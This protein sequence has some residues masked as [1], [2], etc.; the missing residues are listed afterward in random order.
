M[1]RLDHTIKYIINR[2]NKINNI[3]THVMKIAAKS[4]ILSRFSSRLIVRFIAIDR[5]FDKNRCLITIWSAIFFW[6][7]AIKSSKLMIFWGWEYSHQKWQNFDKI[8]GLTSYDI[9]LSMSSKIPWK[10]AILSRFSSRLIVRFYRD[11]IVKIGDFS[12][13]FFKKT[14]IHKDFDE[15]I[16]CSPQ[17]NRRFF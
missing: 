2:I 13:V 4:T 11:K 1:R 17:Y 10:W 5:G 6:K 14:L 15:I 7:I 12:S 16:I 8:D 3:R 9:T